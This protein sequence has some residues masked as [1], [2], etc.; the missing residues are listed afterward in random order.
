MVQNAITAAQ[1]S[2]SSQVALQDAAEPIRWDII[3]TDYDLIQ[4]NPSPLFVLADDF[5]YQESQHSL[6]RFTEIYL[7]M[8]EH[9]T[10]I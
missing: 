8:L 10:F 4:L 6:Q 1:R 3:Y 9:K 5:L 7:P 2:L